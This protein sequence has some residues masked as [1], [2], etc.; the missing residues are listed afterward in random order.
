MLTRV[1]IALQLFDELIKKFVIVDHY[2]GIS[3][4]KY[5]KTLKLD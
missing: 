4:Y 1:N 3:K 2:Q 5:P